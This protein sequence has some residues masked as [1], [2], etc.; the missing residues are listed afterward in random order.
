[1]SRKILIICVDAL[2]PDYLEAADTPNMDRLGREGVFAVGESA[3]P[4]VTNVNNVSI[5]TGAPP[6]VHGVTSNYWIDRATG[7]E[8][9]ME[10][11]EFMR[12]PTVL[13]RARAC[14][15][16]TCL[17]TA[18]KKLLDLLN[19]GADYSLAAEEPDEEMVD[20][21]GAA[22]DIYSIEINLWLFRALEAALDLRKPDVTYCATTDWAMHKYAPEEEESIR[23]V[24]GLDAALGEILAKHPGMEVYIT[25]DHGMSAKSRGVDIEKALARHGVRSRAIPIIKD[26]Y[27]EHHGNLGGAAYVY[28]EDTGQRSKAIEILADT[29]GIEEV[30]G[31]EEA[32]E[33]FELMEE[34][35]G[36]LLVLGDAD[37]VFGSF[38]AESVRVRVRSHG[39]RH[40]SAVPIL[41]YGGRKTARYRRNRDIVAGLGIDQVPS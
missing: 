34:R 11:P 40:E 14:G 24:Q 31:C 19:A 16:S 13:E 39:S 30:Y 6:R 23:H 10:A 37:T 2:G 7:R 28:L 8:S 4:S 5:I 21:L 25:A 29:G 15:M 32:A 1:M 20:K 41:A 17:L 27:V 36:D 38:E 9:Y 12:Y 3:I 18:K 22:P 26:R 35:I 33:R